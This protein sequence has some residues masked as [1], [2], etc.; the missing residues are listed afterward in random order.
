MKL[1]LLCLTGFI[2][3]GCS[4]FTAFPGAY[5]VNAY[6]LSGSRL[7]KVAVISDGSA[8]YRTINA[9]CLAFPGAKLVI[10]SLETKKELSELSPFQ[11]K[12]KK[13]DNAGADLVAPKEITFSGQ[14]YRLAYTNKNKKQTV[15]E[16]TT[17]NERVE[18]WTRLITLLHVKGSENNTTTYA[19]KEALASF[20]NE[21]KKTFVTNGH[22]YIKIVFSPDKQH[23]YYETAIKKTFHEE[24]CGG[25]LVLTYAKKYSVTESMITINNESDRDLV[26]MKEDGWMPD[27]AK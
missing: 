11:C 23:Q 9:S 3:F 5:S 24:D 26:K 21:V 6:D 14:D 13:K 1:I 15:Y 4:T 16:Y 27:C 17:D 7:N 12:E 10:K 8:V 18:G 19:V 20:G 2:M 25:R 22:A